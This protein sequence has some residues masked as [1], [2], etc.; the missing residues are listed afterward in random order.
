MMLP[1]HKDQILLRNKREDH[2]QG[3]RPE[4]DDNELERMIGI[5]QHSL[6][7]STPAEVRLYDP[8][9]VL[10]VIGIVEKIDPAAGW[11]QVGGDR[12]RMADI[13]HAVEPC[14]QWNDSD[15]C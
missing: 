3:R 12:F 2:F 4:L 15:P 7:S 9:E 8:Q 13:I 5:V 14:S 1:E 10:I 6:R 11:F